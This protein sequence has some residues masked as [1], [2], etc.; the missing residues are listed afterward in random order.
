MKADPIRVF[1][2]GATGLVGGALVRALVR[3]GAQVHAL[4][5]RSSDRSSL[6]DVAVTWHEGD[7]TVP[8]SLTG[9]LADAKWIIHASGRLGEAGV[10]ERVYE[11]VNVDGTRNILTKALD[12]RNR[13]R[14]LHVSS[15]GVLGPIAGD[16]ATE[17]AALAPSNPYERSKAAAEE[18]ARGFAARGLEVVIARPEFI[19]GPGDR[20]VLGL[21]KA[22]C[23]G[24][25]FYI[26][27]G[28]HSC[29]PTFIADAVAGM[30]L[31]LSR[32]R[33]GEAYHITGPRP[34][35]FRELGD[36]I[37]NALG[38]R[39][40][41]LSMPKWSASLGATGLEALGRLFALTP[42]LSRSGVAFF[43]EDRRFSWQKAHEELG[44]SPQ[45]DLATGVF[46]TVQWYR[47]H[48]W[49]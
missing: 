30:L 10:P 44:Y 26:N 14:V 31:C 1:V 38:V 21:F 28:R 2:T 12:M 32:G 19:Y 29:H 33:P 39:A 46:Q 25:F 34:I 3:D 6:D 20:H 37:A 45:S 18:V 4:A 35:T 48:G 11:Q 7:V 5:R 22:I 9:I 16:P 13:P 40:P 49:L 23:R 15:P 17:D 27:G 36:T 24:H 41:S 43:S 8:S 47:E 42:P